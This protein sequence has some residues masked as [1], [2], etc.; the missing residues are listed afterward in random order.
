MA[1]KS[2][3]SSNLS[4][5]PAPSRDALS[6]PELHWNDDGQPVATD[7][8]DPY[9]S[10]SHGLEETRHVFLQNNG[11]PERWNTHQGPFHIVE[12]GFGTGLNFLAT[13]QGFKQFNAKH[14]ST[15]HP[16]TKQPPTKQNSLWLHF[17]SIEKYP[18]SKEQLSRA[19]SIWPELSDLAKTLLKRYPPITPGFHTLSWPEEKVTLTLIFADIKDAAK[20]LSA[21]VHAWYLDGF[22]PYKNPDMWADELFTDIRRVS[23]ESHYRGV[24]STFAT[25]TV[26]GVARRGMRGAGFNVERRIGFGKKYEM[27]AG[28]YM[29]FSGPEINPLSYQ[30]PWSSEAPTLKPAAKILI[31][32][33][34]LAGCTT[35]RALA[36]RGYQINVFDPDG[37]ANGASGNVQG[38][39]YVKLAAGDSATHTDFYR[40]AYLHAVERV[41]EILTDDNKGKSWDDCGVLQISWSEKEAQRQ[42]N[43]LA[44]QQPPE[45]LI[46][47]TTV[48]QNQTASGNALSNNSLYFPKAGW[49]APADFCY[50]LLDHPNITF[51]N[52]A[53][54]HFEANNDGVT[55]TVN[56]TSLHADGLII[57][58]SFKAKELLG[59]QIHLPTKRI[60]GQMSYLDPSNLPNAQSV[61][62]ARSYL[63]PALNGRLCLGA[64]YNL[65]DN[66][67]KLRDSDH[68]TNIDHLE[69]FGSEWAA[70]AEAVKVIGGRVSFRCTTP[71][72]LPL[73]G[74]VVDSKL[75]VERFKQITRNAKQ[76][77][78][79]TMPWLPRVW[80]NIGHGSRGLASSP[81]CAEILAAQ[82]SGD[83]PP[84]SN[85]V[86][87][88]LSPSRFIVRALIRSKLPEEL[89]E[90][91]K[92]T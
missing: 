1:Y 10:A 16:S 2:S 45:S 83:A 25:Y 36:E 60:R 63:A 64:T 46:Y 15:K 40:Q 13:W 73:I 38:G 7:F 50:A 62:C 52:Q 11:I 91:V 37:I 84:V 39:L 90:L 55:A 57:A 74:P 48:E 21:P 82:I 9:F 14:S 41:A 29:A 51:Q 86:K 85:I 54:E 75:F 58:T 47:P 88:A 30:T 24:T 87:D 20:Q 32:G 8:D 81:L 22:A 3:D 92:R 70:A 49:V 33:A 27:Q 61:L 71:D 77:P 79:T 43:F 42:Q 66:N 5:K 67:T 69:E 68:Q 17:T 59:E 80:L 72:Y 12:T 4:P 65:N 31:A 26:A 34:G 18:L 76:I 44:R 89:Q 28:H 53:I 19:L 23:R 56:K 6:P 35:A 78:A